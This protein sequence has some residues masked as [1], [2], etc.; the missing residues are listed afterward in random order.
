MQYVS[1]FVVPCICRTE[2]FIIWFPKQGI[3]S[4]TLTSRKSHKLRRFQRIV[5]RWDRQDGWDQYK[6]EKIEEIDEIDGIEE[7]DYMDETDKTDET[8]K[9]YKTDK[10]DK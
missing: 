5:I 7:I 10:I 6:I 8:D 1:Q 9:I 4:L 2:L 3:V